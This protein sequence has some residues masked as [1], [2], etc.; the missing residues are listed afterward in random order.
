VDGDGATREPHAQAKEVAPP[1]PNV[2][3]RIWKDKTVHSANTS[4]STT[5]RSPIKETSES[6]TPVDIG[7]SNDPDDGLPTTQSILSSH[8]LM[9]EED[10]Q[11]ETY[12]RSTTIH[13]LLEL[14]TIASGGAVMQF[15]ISIKDKIEDLVLR[16]AK[17][18]PDQNVDHIFLVCNLHACH[19]VGFF[20][21][22]QEQSLLVL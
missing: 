10:F 21:Q 12:L 17:H 14:V 9:I 13:A 3:C 18:P 4:T 5:Q 6:S 2:S 7:D 22:L 15:D 20:H 8:R 11:P 19:W 16:P 1:P